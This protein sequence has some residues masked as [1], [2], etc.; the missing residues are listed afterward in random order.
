MIT[1]LQYDS[2]LIFYVFGTFLNLYMQ[3]PGPTELGIQIARDDIGRY[4]RLGHLWIGPFKYSVNVHHP[5][6]VKD[7]LKTS[8]M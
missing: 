5:D 4:P 2:K 3:Y 1:K 8:G 7:I 6:P